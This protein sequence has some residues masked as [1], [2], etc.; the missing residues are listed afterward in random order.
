[1]KKTDKATLFGLLLVVTTAVAAAKEAP[2][3]PAAARGAW[4]GE[5]EIIVTW[6][7][8]DRLPVE[9]TIHEDG[10]VTGTAGDATLSDGVFRRNNRL[11]TALGNAEYYIQANLEGPLVRAERIERDSIRIFVDLVD[12]HIEGGFHTSGSKVGGKR[13]M[14]MTGARLRMSKTETPAGP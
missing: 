6:C 5:A 2:A 10:T 3:P 14:K 4:S 12:D 8:Q 11:L 9:V 13:S 7:E 1:M